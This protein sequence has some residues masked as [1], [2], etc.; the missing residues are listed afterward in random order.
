MTIE[1]FLD[2]VHR[3]AKEQD[4]ILAVAIVGSYATGTAGPESDVDLLILVP[5]PRAYP[6]RTDW[7]EHFGDIR[8]VQDEDWGLLAVQTCPL[9]QRVGSGIRVR[10]PASANI[11]PIDPGTRE[12]VAGGLRVLFPLLQRVLEAVQSGQ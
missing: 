9:C 4:D 7:M 1:G 12:V 6:L 11:E 2:S 8:S 5:D 3:W 10:P